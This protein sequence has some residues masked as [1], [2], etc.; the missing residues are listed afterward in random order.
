MY[1]TRILLPIVFVVF[2]STA[3][4]VKSEKTIRPDWNTFTEPEPV[5]AVNVD[6]DR[7]VGDCVVRPDL[8][9]AANSVDPPPSEGWFVVGDRALRA[10]GGTPENTT[11]P[12]IRLQPEERDVD[13]PTVKSQITWC[14]D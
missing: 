2:A 9:M 12:V 11:Y 10:S 1:L 3:L 8:S 5:A 7:D 14:S 6:P 4:A 13:E